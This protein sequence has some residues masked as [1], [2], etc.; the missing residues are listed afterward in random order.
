[1]NTFNNHNPDKNNQ[2]NSVYINPG[3]Q[4]LLQA[5]L[6][7][8]KQQ[9]V[10]FIIEQDLQRNDH[11]VTTRTFP[12]HLFE[13]PSL[14]SNFHTMQ[15]VI[16]LAPH[17]FQPQKVLYV[18]KK[19]PRKFTAVLADYLYK[20]AYQEKLEVFESKQLE[21]LKFIREPFR[22]GIYFQEYKYNIS[23]L[24]I[25][26]LKHFEAQGGTVKVN[27]PTERNEGKIIF[28]Q[29][30]EKVFGEHV[31]NCKTPESTNYLIP[32]NAP[33]GFS[34]VFQD[35]TQAFRFS[36]YDDFL[37]AEPLDEASSRIDEQNFL[38]LVQKLFQPAI[39]EAQKKRNSTAPISGIFQ[40]L[41]RQ[42]E[43]PLACTFQNLEL[44]DI[45]EHCLEKYDLAKQTGIS[46]SN[47]KVLYHRYGAAINEMTE[48]A[49]SKMNTFRNPAKIWNAAEQKYQKEKEW[50]T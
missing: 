31:I 25:E 14:Q 18:S 6:L 50:G 12:F 11:F 48:E 5:S 32:I 35:S 4:E 15:K 19:R 22:K 20:N 47:F 17:L 24:F 9:K 3:I 37:M 40:M 7:L 23:R 38:S 36:E 34:M 28:Q 16:A 13:I 49:Y 33:T 2:F 30:R 41:D 39:H 43:H 45:H 44:K 10:L 21:Q 42:M 46:Y 26:L 27:C 29:T 8:K 1:M